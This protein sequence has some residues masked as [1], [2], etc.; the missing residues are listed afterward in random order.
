MFFPMFLSETS[1]YH[2]D[3]KIFFSSIKEEN[4]FNDIKIIIQNNIENFQ[5]EVFISLEIMDTYHS[6]FIKNDNNGNLTLPE[7]PNI[8]LDKKYIIKDMVISLVKFHSIYY[9]FLRNNGL[10]YFILIFE[11]FYQFFSLVNSEKIDYENIII[12]KIN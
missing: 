12:K 8:L 11:Y 5:L 10:D 1:F 6:L 2:F 9:D 7:I 4:D 3:E